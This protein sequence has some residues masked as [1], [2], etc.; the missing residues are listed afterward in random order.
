MCSVAKVLTL[1]AP[2]SPEWLAARTGKIGGTAAVN[3]LCGADRNLRTFGS[4]LTEFLRLTGRAPDDAL[5]DA[6]DELKQI[7]R[8]GQQSEPLHRAMLAEETHGVFE[9]PPGVLQHETIPWLAVS[10]DGRATVPGLGRGSLEL[11]APTRHTV[12]EWEAGAPVTYQVQ[13]AAVMFVE[14]LPFCLVSAL[15]PPTTKWAI[16]KRD[17]TFEQFMLD[18]LGHFWTQHVEKDIPPPAT[19]RPID[20]AALYRLHPRDNGHIVTLPDE[21]AAEFVALRSETEALDE[22]E[23]R[24]AGRKARIAQA[25]GPNT[26]GRVGPYSATHKHQT[27]TVA[28]KSCGVTQS[29]SEFRVFR[30]KFA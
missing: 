25:I 10:P 28:C 7:L 22:I 14:D 5:A 12:D 11:K 20:K 23:A 17:P 27:R 3:I 15:I 9:G 19:F 24:V 26:G 1:A 2:G 4:P 13:G 8:W 6:D 29:Q 21:F 30:P 16:V 18:T